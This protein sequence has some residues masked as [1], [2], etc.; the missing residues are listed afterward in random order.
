VRIQIPPQACAGELDL[1]PNVRESRC[2]ASSSISACGRASK[3]SSTIWPGKQCGASRR[4]DKPSGAAGKTAAFI[5]TKPRGVA[6]VTGGAG[7][8][9]RI[10]GLLG[11]IFTWGEKRGFVSGANPCHRLELRADGAEDRM[12]SAE[13]LVRLGEVL[14]R[15]EADA[16]LAVAALKLIALT[17]LR[18]AEAYGLRWAEIDLEGSCLRLTET[19]SGRSMRA[20]GVAALEHLRSLP[21]LH[22]EFVFPNVLGSGPADL[23]KRIAAL[24]NEAGLHDARGHDLRRTFASLAADEGYSD[25]TIG[26]LLGH[27]RHGVTRKHYIRRPD[28]ALIA[29]ADRVSGRIASLLDRATDASTVI[30]FPGSVSA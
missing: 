3:N 18:R 14:R 10:V 25:A 23:V 30:P 22:P 1:H 4:K 5:K 8:A 20:I 19:K 27:A 7:N 26:E 15:H 28:A 12:L 13:E 2:F 24:F 17:G 16:P 9:T 6:R 29:A 21:R 11:G